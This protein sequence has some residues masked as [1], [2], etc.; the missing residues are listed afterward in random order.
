MQFHQHAH[1]G[2]SSYRRRIT[3][4]QKQ[5]RTE[6]NVKYKSNSLHFCFLHYEIVQLLSKARNIQ[7]KESWFLNNAAAQN[8][9]HT[10]ENLLIASELHVRQR[11]AFGGQY[12]WNQAAI[13]LE[14]EPLFTITAQLQCTCQ[15]WYTEIK[16]LPSCYTSR[17]GLHSTYI[18]E[19]RNT[20]RVVNTIHLS[21]GLW[22][23][24]TC[25]ALLN[26]PRSFKPLSPTI[27]SPFSLS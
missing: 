3:G 12:I 22:A 17:T 7:A 23:L 24:P 18:A 11:W 10:K 1:W 6:Q 20:V 25:S 2:P 27:T 13:K 9:V 5:H 15:S 8:V 4:T 26:Q 19:T 14:G 21:D 16:W